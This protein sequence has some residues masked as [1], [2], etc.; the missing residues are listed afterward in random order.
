MYALARMNRP[1]MARR[2]PRFWFDSEAF[3]RPI[4]DMIQSGMRTNVRETEDAYLLEADLP[5]FEREEIDLSLKEGMLTI[6]AEHKE[7]NEENEAFS[8][9]SVQRSFSVEG[10]DEEAITAQYKNG[11]LLVQL[12]K[13]KA[14]DE[15]EAR[16]I[17][18]SE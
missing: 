12:P 1:V 5:G 6:T 14:P 9:R 18:I 17:A 8:S 2:Q 16:K 3:F 4:S 15:P 13:Q 11:V 10:V 7:K